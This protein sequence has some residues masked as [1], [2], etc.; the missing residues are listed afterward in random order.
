MSSPIGP[1]SQRVKYFIEA[2]M[3][4]T[5][6]MVISSPDLD[7]TLHFTPMLKLLEIRPGL[8]D[9]HIIACLNA[10]QNV[11]GNRS[12]AGFM[13]AKLGWVSTG[14]DTSPLPTSPN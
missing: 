14:A 9:N 3:L 1:V 10:A 6:W 8:G 12:A 5:G 7:T 4:L 2:F 11:I 13:A